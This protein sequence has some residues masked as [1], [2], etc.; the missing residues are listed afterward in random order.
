MQIDAMMSTY[1]F[2]PLKMDLYDFGVVSKYGEYA[3]CWAPTN[4]ANATYFQSGNITVDKQD[5]YQ[6]LSDSASIFLSGDAAMVLGYESSALSSFAPGGYVD[7]AKS[8]GFTLSGW[9]QVEDV[10]AVAGYLLCK[11]AASGTTR[12]TGSG[13]QRRWGVWIEQNIRHG[14]RVTQIVLWNSVPN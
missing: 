13:Q 3:M 5:Y 14:S 2:A 4:A 6:A 11:D 10:P 7:P 1:K 9:L 12:D 8:N